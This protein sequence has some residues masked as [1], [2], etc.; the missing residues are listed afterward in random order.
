MLRA[1][2]AV[3]PSVLLIVSAFVSLFAYFVYP[4]SPAASQSASLFAATGWP[5]LVWGLLITLAS[6]LGGSAI[7]SSLS[8]ATRA[9]SS[10]YQAARNML[11][12]LADQLGVTDDLALQPA[13]ATDQPPKDFVV[14][15]DRYKNALAH[16]TSAV[17]SLNKA[18]MQWVS[19]A[20]YIQLWS[21]LYR[22]D[23]A[24][25][26][27]LPLKKV[28]ELAITDTQRLAGS[29][30]PTRD[31]LLDRL[32]QAI[33]QLGPT[34]AAKLNPRPPS[35]PSEDET[36]A[37]EAIRAVRR[38]LNDFVA[39]RYAGIIAARNLLTQISIGL[40][41][42]T[43]VMFLL[44]LLGQTSPGLVLALTAFYLIGA[45]MGFLNLLI[46]HLNKDTSIEDYGR[47]H[48][49]MYI[50]PSLAGLAA[51]AG[52]F[53]AHVVGA[54]LAGLSSPG[55]DIASVFTLNAHN[56]LL[57][58]VFGWT[59]QLVVSALQ[60]QSDRYLSEIKSTLATQD[61]TK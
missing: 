44:V 19:G 51:V 50:M 5:P 46:S 12:D 43:Y 3:F 37:R 31:T 42:V 22:A 48:A 11:S 40:G 30:I 21:A 61:A 20:G 15:M 55:N 27:C 1:T 23:E 29:Q 38:E 59:P 54:P 13:Q 41:L 10:S 33:V 45:G 49:R 28:T 60:Q 57:A 52:V 34:A 8:S 4:G 18:G 53:L 24:T 39:Q 9:S 47:S 58:A 14:D 26:L 32:R 36:G 35:A 56:A 17:Q 2:S 25:I 6:W 7:C 16:R